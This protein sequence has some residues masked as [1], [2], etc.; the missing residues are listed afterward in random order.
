MASAIKNNLTVVSNYDETNGRSITM[1]N[2]RTTPCGGTH[3]TCLG[4]I[5]E[6]TIR[7]L[8]A[9][10]GCLKVGYNVA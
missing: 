6:V 4:E 2:F 5:G 7:K 1:G 9:K 10:K 3:V 8:E